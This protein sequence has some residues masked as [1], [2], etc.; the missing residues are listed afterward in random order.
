RR[1][2]PSMA[3]APK[4]DPRAKENIGRGSETRKLGPQ[5][6]D[7]RPRPPPGTQLS[8]GSVSVLFG[9]VPVTHFLFAQ[10]PQMPPRVQPRIMPVRPADLERV[11][12]YK[13]QLP[14]RT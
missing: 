3:L 12:T 13:L 7:L 8:R 4:N 6:T 1:P 14:N 11:I 10:P 5:Y 9:D 2:G